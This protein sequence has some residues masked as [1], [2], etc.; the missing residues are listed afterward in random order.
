M[1]KLYKIKIYGWFIILALILT[2]ILVV[3]MLENTRLANIIGAFLTY[4][5][6]LGVFYSHDKVLWDKK[7]KEEEEDKA[8]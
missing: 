2:S 6:I 7:I 3:Y 1:F 8:K 5:I 4:V